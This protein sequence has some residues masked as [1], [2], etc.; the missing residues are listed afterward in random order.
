MGDSKLSGGVDWFESAVG[1]GSFSEQF[2]RYHELR[3]FQAMAHGRVSTYL[4]C[5]TSPGG[6]AWAL[7]PN[8][9]VPG[10]HRRGSVVSAGSKADVYHFAETLLAAARS[11]RY[12]Y[13]SRSEAV[14]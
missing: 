11:H 13:L 3:S 6:R 10:V 14:C 4:E 12:R 1:H 5:G 8:L 9:G 2:D 7:A